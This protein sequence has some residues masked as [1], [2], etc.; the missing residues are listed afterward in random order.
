M[1]LTVEGDRQ[2]DQPGG[3]SVR[4]LKE[5]PWKTGLWDVAEGRQG[6]SCA[7]MLLKPDHPRGGGGAKNAQVQT[8]EGEG[9]MKHF[10]C[11]VPLPR[12][13]LSN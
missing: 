6:S 4:R 2:R 7:E 10:P 5:P 11:L 12:P 8:V 9:K 13:L 3:V 1:Q